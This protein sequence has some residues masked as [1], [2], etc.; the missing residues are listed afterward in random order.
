M[1]GKFSEP[2]T[3]TGASR[4]SKHLSEIKPASDNAKELFT[5]SSVTI[6]HRPCLF[7]EDKIVSSSRGT[8]VRRSTISIF[9]EKFKAYLN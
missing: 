6:K 2:I 1:A 3:C 8:N 9:S 7:T 5:G 4:F